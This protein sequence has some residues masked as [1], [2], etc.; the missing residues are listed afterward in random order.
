MDAGDMDTGTTGGDDDMS[1]PP[2]VYFGPE[3]P[4]NKPGPNWL[5]MVCVSDTHN[6]TDANNYPIPEADILVH[7]GDFTK[8]GTT[9][10]IDQ[11]VCWLKSLKHIPVK[12]VVAGNHDVILDQAF[13][14]RRWAS[15]HQTK[16]DHQVALQKLES[17][18]HGI[19]YLD[20]SPF[21]V[22]GG[23][24]LYKKWQKQLKQTQKQDA[25]AATESGNGDS[26][27]DAGLTSAGAGSVPGGIDNVAV[28]PRE[29]WTQGYKIWASPWQPEFYDWAFNEERGKLHE[30]WKHI[31]EDTEIL[32]THGPPKYYGDIVPHQRERH[33][34]C[35]EL[36]ERLKA[37]RPL[38][39]VF[40]HI[41]EGYSITQ[42]DWSSHGASSEG[43]EELTPTSTVCI[44]ASVCNVNYR[45]VNPPIVV[46]L[47]PK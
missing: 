8:M 39:H 44:N 27:G 40:G 38:Y 9:A 3:V 22:E 41:H 5:R 12:V 1:L 47:P 2:N 21:Q 43:S 34:G 32:I 25:T 18:G 45:P 42:I 19:V 15:F 28:D 31:P 11:F 16:E 14:E 4:A 26:D 30:I 10:Q 24:I 17:A 20:N 23:K 29:G 36:L 33:V 35:R 37:V 7:A 13:Y 6:M 46:D